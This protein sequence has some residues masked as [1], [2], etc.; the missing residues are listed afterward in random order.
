MRRKA[1]S[2][3]GGTHRLVDPSQVHPDNLLLARRAAALLR[4][5]LAGI[6]LISPDIGQAWH[7]NGAVICEANA[8]PQ[9]GFRDLPQLYTELLQ[10]MLGPGPEV[11]FHGLLLDSRDPVSLPQAWAALAGQQAC[12]AW[13]DPQGAWLDGHQLSHAPADSVAAA[14]TLLMERGL[15]AA[16]LVLRA[17]DVVRQG[18]PVG[19]LRTL[20]LLQ[21]PDAAAD[22]PDAV[23]QQAWQMSLPH[24]DRLIRYSVAAKPAS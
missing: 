9:L 15:R 2:S 5:D 23:M 11:V 14:R 1:N 22:A 6:D 10:E 17:E 3:A 8:Q 21:R 24:A 4:L 18:L 12:N 16:L 19:R 13:S 20:G 7:R